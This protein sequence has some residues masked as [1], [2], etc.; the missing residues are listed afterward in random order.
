M[1]RALVLTVVLAFAS[2]AHAQRV[3]TRP[4]AD[5]APPTL[6]AGLEGRFAAQ[7]YD[8]LPYRLLTPPG[9][10]RHPLVLV[11]HGSGAIGSDNLSQ[12]GVFARAWAEPALADLDAYVAV[13]QAPTRSADYQPD[14]DGLLASRPGS[15]LPAILALVEDM[16]TRLPVDRSRIYLVGFSMGGS[17]ALQALLLKPDLFAAAVAFSPVPPPRDRAARLA[18]TPMMLVHGTADTENPYAPD[19]AWAQAMARAGGHPRVIVYDG[20][21]HRVPPDMLA[22]R[23]WRDWLFAQRR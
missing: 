22:A 21:D 12:L 19:Q 10:G 18:A 16:A 20:M 23:D 3:E 17:A 4:F 15:S 2:G 6:S 9:P 1:I 11:L 7:T 8:G 14:A 5:A 13:P